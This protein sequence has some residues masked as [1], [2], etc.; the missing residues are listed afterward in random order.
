MTKKTG[1][2]R[3]FIVDSR[4]TTFIFPKAFDW[5]G[6]GQRLGF[7]IGIALRAQIIKATEL[8]IAGCRESSASI[9]QNEA[10]NLI[11]A[12]QNQTRAVRRE[13]WKAPVHSD[14][15]FFKR[16][17]NPR[18]ANPTL[19]L[20]ILARSMDGALE[21]SE[22]VAARI[23][24]QSY[25]GTRDQDRWSIWIALLIGFFIAAGYTH[26]NTNNY[27]TMNSLFAAFIEELQTNFPQIARRRATPA[28]IRKAIKDIHKWR[29]RWD[30]KS[31][32]KMLTIWGQRALPGFGKGPL[33]EEEQA[34][35]IAVRM[36]I[37]SFDRTTKKRN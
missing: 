10:L 36:N 7:T 3:R 21:T 25:P 34:K 6:C 17:N 11:R 37:F 28:S 20:E 2:G 23:R 9:T 18:V 24:D 16:Y 22:A 35:D 13:I 12:W 29:R 32:E 4:P 19:D 33:P 30:V 31:L 27:K 14:L 5:N 8:Y 1:D 15:T 26:A